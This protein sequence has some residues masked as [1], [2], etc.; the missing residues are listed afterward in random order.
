MNKPY[1]KSYNEDGSV[2]DQFEAVTDEA[3]GKVTRIY[4]SIFNNRQSR[5][6]AFKKNP[7]AG[8]DGRFGLVV[9][10]KFKYRKRLQT[11]ITKTGETK[12]IKHYD[13]KGNNY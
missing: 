2:V 10:G 8:N 11:I 9:G 12:V 4:K 5:K 13:L 7:F 1:V 3:T 6:S